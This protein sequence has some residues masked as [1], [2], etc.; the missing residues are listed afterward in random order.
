MYTIVDDILLSKS[1][2]FVLIP[3]IYND[4]M[5]MKPEPEPTPVKINPFVYLFFCL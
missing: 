4:F 2:E 1:S 5:L 3:T